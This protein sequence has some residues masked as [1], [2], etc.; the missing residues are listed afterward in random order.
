MSLNFSTT[1]LFRSDSL[2]ACQM[3]QNPGLTGPQFAWRGAHLAFD[4][5]PPTDN[6]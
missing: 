1:A 5:G 3:G 4:I 6:G 2:F